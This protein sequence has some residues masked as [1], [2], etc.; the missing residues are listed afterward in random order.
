MTVTIHFPRP[1]SDGDHS[2]IMPFDLGRFLDALEHTPALTHGFGLHDVRKI[3]FAWEFL[4]LEM[5]MHGYVVDLVDG[6]RL[7]LEVDQQDGQDVVTI[8]P[9]AAGGMPLREPA[10]ERLAPWYEA[11]HITLHIAELKLLPPQIG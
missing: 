5:P 11:H 7:G 3:P 9:L 6:R 2:E 10:D 4:D 1:A 8:E